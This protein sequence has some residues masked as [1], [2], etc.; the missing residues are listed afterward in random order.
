M[1]EI[2]FR[3]W[4]EEE[5]IMIFWSLNDLLVRFNTSDYSQEDKPSVF[6]K[7]MQYTGLKDSNGKE[8]YEGDLIKKEN[9]II[10]AVRWEKDAWICPSIVEKEKGKETLFRLHHISDVVEVIGNIYEHSH[11]LDNTDMKG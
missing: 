9:G 11:L 1:R 3:A 2:K 5:N 10:R 6:F 8:I 7:W 4:N